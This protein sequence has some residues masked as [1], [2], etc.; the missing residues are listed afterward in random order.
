VS[1]TGSAAAPQLGMVVHEIATDGLPPDTDEM[2]GRVAFIFDGC[3][4]SGSPAGDENGPDVW[5]TDEDVGKDGLFHEV[6]HWVE[7]SRPLREV[8]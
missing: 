4:V 7:F 1:E 6:C 8:H 3:I 5:E 2:V